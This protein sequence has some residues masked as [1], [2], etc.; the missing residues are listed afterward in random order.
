VEPFAAVAPER[1]QLASTLVLYEWMADAVVLV[2][3]SFLGFLAVGSLLAWRWPRLVWL[4]VPAVIWAI[5]SVSVGLDCPLTPLE[6][7]FRTLAGEGGYAGG[8]IDRYIEGVI[9]PERFT[10]VLRL[11]VVALVVG[12]YARMLTSAGRTREWVDAEREL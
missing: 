7:D 5:L 2:H 4:H 12:G 3:L 8:F 1:A 9:Y 6:K 10:I 11:L